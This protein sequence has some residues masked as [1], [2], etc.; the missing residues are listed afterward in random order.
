MGILG[1]CISTHNTHCHGHCQEM[2]LESAQPGAEGRGQTAG[3]RAGAAP[4]PGTQRC[5]DCWPPP[6]AL[7]TVAAE[8]CSGDGM[9][10][11]VPED[12]RQAVA[13]CRAQGVGHGS[14]WQLTCR[15]TSRERQGPGLPVG[16][17]GH[18]VWG[19]VQ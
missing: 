10:A 13:S 8:S 17:P 19:L 4:P 1:G 14:S 15:A 16:G 18:L 5:S 9:E 2:Y 11:D 7:L 3:G 6:R 12:S